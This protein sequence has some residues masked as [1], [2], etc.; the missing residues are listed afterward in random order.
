M[1][2]AETIISPAPLFFCLEQL[3]WSE[4]EKKLLAYLLRVLPRDDPDY[5]EVSKAVECLLAGL[6]WS[7]SEDELREKI[8]VIAEGRSH[9]RLGEVYIP[10]VLGFIYYVMGFERAARP[11]SKL[12]NVADCIAISSYTAPL[13]M[14]EETFREAMILATAWRMKMAERLA[15]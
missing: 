4:A 13:G 14:L 6:G 5:E 15:R 10:G 1:S 3:P 8:D 12:L 2:R 9:F 7:C 11:G